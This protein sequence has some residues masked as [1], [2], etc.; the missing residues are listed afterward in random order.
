MVYRVGHNRLGWDRAG[1]GG[2]GQSRALKCRVEGTSVFVYVYSA[3]SGIFS[4]VKS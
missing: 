2:P 1:Q 4:F 3:L